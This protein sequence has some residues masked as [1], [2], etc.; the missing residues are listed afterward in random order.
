MRLS[1]SSVKDIEH[2]VF[3]CSSLDALVHSDLSAEEEAWLRGNLE[4]QKIIHLPHWPQHHYWVYQPPSDKKWA[5][6]QEAESWRI[7]G[8]RLLALLSQHGAVGV[9]IESLGSMES[10]LIAAF[11][12]GLLLGAYRFE[13]HRSE[14]KRSTSKWPEQ[15]QVPQLSDIELKELE[16]Q[17]AGCFLARDL[18]NQPLNHLNATQLAQAAQ[19]AA[20]RFGFKCETLSQK[21]IESLKMGGLLSVNLGSVDPPSFSILEYR[22]PEARNEKPIVLVGKGIV[23]DTG[24]LSLK[25][26]ANSMDSMK[27]D[28]AGAAAAI[29][30]MSAAAQAQLPLHL[31]ALIPATDNRPGGNAYVPGDII[32][33]YDGTTVEVLNTDAE[34]R[35]ILADALAYAKKYKPQLVIDLATLTGAAAVAIGPQGLMCMGTAEEADFSR[36]LRAGEACYER[37]APLPFWDEYAELIK[38]PVADLKNIGGREAGAITAGKFLEHFTDYPWIHLDI[39]GPAFRNSADHY[40]PQGGTGVGVRLLF[41]FLKSLS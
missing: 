12:E 26:T 25:P 30:A 32:R 16:A 10:P 38:S 8:N 24:G 31:I 1:N 7:L 34:G 37:C 9:Q 41:Q 35:L 36:L 20:E 39:A 4:K 14:A 28:M 18:V 15:L 40:R 6:G 33:M 11:S 3:L 13:V 27:S 23:Y 17:V 21:K 19:E 2:Q 22:S 5:P 29:G